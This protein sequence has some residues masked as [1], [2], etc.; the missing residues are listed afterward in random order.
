MKLSEKNK[1]LE[2]ELAEKNAR[3]TDSQIDSGR[4]TVVN[5]AS[6]LIGEE[7]K[8]EVPP[9]RNQIPAKVPV[10]DSFKDELSFY[11]HILNRYNFK[12]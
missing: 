2:S 9:L 7:M 6:S 3:I 8:E 5:S 12:V 10:P 4:H 11:S 1:K